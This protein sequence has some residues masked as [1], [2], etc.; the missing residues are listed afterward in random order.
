MLLVTRPS[1][2][3]ALRMADTSYTFNSE[4]LVLK[5][6]RLEPI[7]LFFN[8]IKNVYADRLTVRCQRSMLQRRTYSDGQIYRGRTSFL[9][10]LIPSVEFYRAA[11]TTCLQAYMYS[12]R[13]GVVERLSAA[14]PASE[15]GAYQE[16][17]RTA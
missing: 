10:V 7:S 9:L 5:P 3:T 13:R 6:R 15:S 16:A 1:V 11:I 8:I 2:V 14:Q 4:R 12:R 17:G